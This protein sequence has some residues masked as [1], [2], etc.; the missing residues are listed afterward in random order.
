M[1]EHY[2]YVNEKLDEL[3]RARPRRPQQP[4][5]PRP[6]PLGGAAVTLG[7]RVR[8]IGEALESWGQPAPRCARS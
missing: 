2:L 8:R 3:E 7:R 5:S 6:R 1:L 4:Q